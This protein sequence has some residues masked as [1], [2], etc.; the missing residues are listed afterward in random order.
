MEDWY[1]P[2]LPFVNRLL[3]CGSQE[4]QRLPADGHFVGPQDCTSGTRLHFRVRFLC[5]ELKEL[6]GSVVTKRL[7][8]VLGEEL[9]L[10]WQV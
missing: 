5:P 2:T 7:L 6:L 3:G 10:G 9:H 4:V 1:E 8:A